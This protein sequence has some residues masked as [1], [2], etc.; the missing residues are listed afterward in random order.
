M[1]IFAKRRRAVNFVGLLA[2]FGMGQGSLFVAQTWLLATGQIVFMG[3]FSFIFTM[4]IL[5]Y[6]AIDLGGLVI[7]ARRVAA[8]DHAGHELPTF[9]WSFSLIRFLI[10]VALTIAAVV[11]WVLSPTSFDSN[12]ALAAAPGLVIFS[13]NPGGV[14]DG[15]DRS[16]WTGATWALPFVASTIVLPFSAHEPPV[17][18]GMALGMALSIGAM[19]A[20]SAQ[21]V[22]LHRQGSGITWRRPS[23]GAMR[24][25]GQEALLYM[26]GWLPG[27]L[28]FRGQTGIAMALLGPEQTALFI[29]AK[30]L[31]MSG[32]RFLYFARRIEYANL[33]KV[34]ADRQRLVLK[35]M[36]VQRISIYMGVLG[37]VAFAAIGIVMHLAFPQKLHGA[38]IVIAIFSPI[39][40]T[41]SMNA[42]FMQA[43]YAVK[44]T[45][46]SAWTALLITVLGLLLQAGLVP[47]MGMS[48]I[49]L[50]EGICQISG[51]VL[52]V[53]ALNGRIRIGTRGGEVP[54]AAE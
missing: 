5:S 46:T 6:Q 42:A 41:A 54:S 22:L 23:R 14:L 10:A 50:A 24:E 3:R 27:Q 31:I 1:S 17:I 51:A 7:L 36:Q 35:V 45:D 12:Y 38:G 49:A 13:V 8:D 33:V 11:W 9:Y 30:Q 39:V 48:G 40:L 15:Y 37:M 4:V 18:A 44:R 43:C 34:L 29:Y 20:V 52:I 53:L 2:G 25:S 16:G 32:T 28:Y 26:I 21:Y 47:F 19:L